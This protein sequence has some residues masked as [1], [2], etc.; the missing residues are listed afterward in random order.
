MN[1]DRHDGCEA[2]ELAGRARGLT[3]RFGRKDAVRGV[4][5]DLD[6]GGV[7]VLLGANGAGKTTFL[8]L[9]LGLIRPTA[10]TIELLGLDPVT[11][12]DALRRRVGVVPDHPDAYGWMTPARWFDFL[13]PHYP[14]WDEALAG[15]IADEL[16]VPLRTRFRSLSRGEATKAMLV[17][18][19]A[20]R[21]DLLVLDEPFGRLDPIAREEVL[22]AV[23]G[24]IRERGRTVLL[25]THDLDL[26][27]R[28][29]DRVLVMRDGRIVRDAAPDDLGDPGA[30][31]PTTE[32]LRHALLADHALATEDAPCS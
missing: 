18:A 2:R 15:A 7:T 28:V 23:I 13:A 31:T 21:P 19:V 3:K 16:G 5:L 25:S 30:S 6:A 1:D 20:F 22:R 26:A 27:A 24:Q 17:A 9:L 10:G 14:T 4:D 32:R 11:D 8:R 29:A 12:G